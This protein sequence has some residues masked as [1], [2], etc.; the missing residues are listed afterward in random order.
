MH[1]V[2]AIVVV[3]VSVVV[4]VVLVVVV[5]PPTTETVVV[6]TGFPALTTG[7]GV[8]GIV[9]VYGVVVVAWVTVFVGGSVVVFCET[10]TGRAFQRFPRIAH[11]ERGRNRR[12]LLNQPHAS[13]YPGHGLQPQVEQSASASTRSPKPHHAEETET[14]HLMGDS[15]AAG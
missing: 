4:L 15:R 2:H 6:V 13:T 8:G 3:T 1:P 14:R 10:L 5:T 7:A 9:P 11:G 12:A